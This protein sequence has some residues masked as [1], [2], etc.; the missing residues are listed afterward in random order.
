MPEW[1][2]IATYGAWHPKCPT[3]KKLVT[4]TPGGSTAIDAP[5]RRYIVDEKEYADAPKPF[6]IDTDRHEELT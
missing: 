2:T 5:R 4:A 3:G 6:V 1:I